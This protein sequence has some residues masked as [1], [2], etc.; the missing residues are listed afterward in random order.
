ML[1]NINE[2][3]VASRAIFASNQSSFSR[4]AFFKSA[5][6]RDVAFAR[7]KVI[8]TNGIFTSSNSYKRFFPQWNFSIVEN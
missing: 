4:F 7:L 3:A 2:K 5:R 6:D 8:L 1:L